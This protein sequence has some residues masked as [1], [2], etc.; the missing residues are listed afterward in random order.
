MADDISKGLFYKPLVEV[1]G[2]ETVLKGFTLPALPQALMQ[3]IQ[4]PCIDDD[5]AVKILKELSRKPD[6]PT[7]MGYNK[8]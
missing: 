5:L 4:H 1:I 7:I 3:W 2:L 6:A 8:S